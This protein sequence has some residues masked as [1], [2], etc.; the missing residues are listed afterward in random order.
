MTLGDSV[1]HIVN[2]SLFCHVYLAYIAPLLSL[3]LSSNVFTIISIA[4]IECYKDKITV[5]DL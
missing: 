5:Y 4:R 1:S 3:Q 2:S